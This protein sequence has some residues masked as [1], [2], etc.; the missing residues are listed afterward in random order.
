MP[1]PAEQAAIARAYA[2]SG[3]YAEAYRYIES[4]IRGDSAWHP[5][6]ADWF[7]DAAKINGGASISDNSIDA[8]SIEY[9]LDRNRKYLVAAVR[10][11]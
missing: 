3:N 9:I 1:T 6:L 11:L 10:V 8:L 5:G 7:G 4:Q 2:N